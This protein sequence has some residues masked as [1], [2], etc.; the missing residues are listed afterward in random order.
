MERDKLMRRCG[1]WLALL[2]FCVGCTQR[3]PAAVLPATPLPL[4]ET[5]LPPGDYQRLAWLD[6]GLVVQTHLAPP[7]PKR[8]WLYWVSPDGSLGDPLPLP[9]DPDFASTQYKSPYRLPDGRLSMI[10]YSSSS[11]LVGVLQ[12]RI[13]LQVYDPATQQTGLLIAQDLPKFPIGQNATFA[14]SPDLR[15]AFVTDSDSALFWWTA[16]A[17]FEPFSESVE[18][19][20]LIAWSPD[21]A[22]IAYQDVHL[23]Y[24][25]SSLYLL[26]ADGR[27]KRLLVD[28]V[29]SMFDLAWSPNGRWLAFSGRFDRSATTSAQ[30]WLINP[31]TGERLQLLASPGQFNALAWS[32]DSDQIAVSWENQALFPPNQSILTLDLPGELWN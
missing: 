1:R 16:K 19:N 32:P 28:G 20:D 27:N 15:R 22:T 23:P 5:T 6:Q 9:L 21:G 26:D 8:L 12:E 14:W 29:Y 2:V 3:M 31:Q 13:T 7:G 17:G 24:A 4:P 18:L 10:G 25:P 11:P 30:I